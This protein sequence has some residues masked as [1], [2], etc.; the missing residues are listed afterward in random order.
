MI[1]NFFNFILLLLVTTLMSPFAVSAEETKYSQNTFNVDINDD[2]MIWTYMVNGEETSITFQNDVCNVEGTFIS[3]DIT[4][5]TIKN[6]DN[7][8]QVLE[9]LE[10]VSGINVVF[11]DNVTVIDG[12]LFLL[13]ENVCDGIKSIT[14]GNNTQVIGEYEFS[15]LG[16]DTLVIPET[17]QKIGVGAFTDCYNLKDV[18]VLSKDISIENSGIGYY[19]GSQIENMIIRGYINSTASAYALNND[20]TF[21]PINAIIGDVSFNGN[22]DL[23]DVVEIAKYIMSMRTFTDD[24]YFIADYNQDNF[25]NLYDAIEIIQLI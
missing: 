7:L 12:Q 23:Y 17:I 24:E 25:V 3:D 9:W 1:K 14:L 21:V 18:T 16:F 6:A 20:F 8:V 22:I 5:L 2:K 10:S 19:K 15:M 13:I 11:S 4:Q